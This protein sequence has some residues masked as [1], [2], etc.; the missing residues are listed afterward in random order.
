M[1]SRQYQIANL[2]VF[3]IG[4]DDFGI[5][6]IV[7][8]ITDIPPNYGA[9]ECGADESHQGETRQKRLQEDVDQGWD[10]ELSSVFV[11]DFSEHD[12]SEKSFD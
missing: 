5:I 1:K 11:Q 9:R 2:C 6:D 12:L 4:R 7:K 8:Y 3:R 10:E